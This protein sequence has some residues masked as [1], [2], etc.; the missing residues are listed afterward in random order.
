MYHGFDAYEPTSFD[1][2]GKE[3]GVTRERVRRLYDTAIRKLRHSIQRGPTGQ[4]YSD[5][6]TLLR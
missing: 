2:I 1:G 5:V 3:I 4:R 6:R